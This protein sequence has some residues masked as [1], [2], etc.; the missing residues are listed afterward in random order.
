MQ[1][2]L[3]GMGWP[4]EDPGT[5]LPQIR[6]SEDTADPQVAA[7]V[8]LPSHVLTGPGL[9]STHDELKVQ[10]LTMQVVRGLLRRD[11]GSSILG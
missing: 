3:N 4:V 11:S 2:L 7:E 1:V 5:V 6:T 8:A 9:R 10:I